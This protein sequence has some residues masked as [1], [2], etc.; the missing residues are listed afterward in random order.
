FISPE[1]KLVTAI[2]ICEPCNS[3]TFRIEGTELACGNCETRWKLNN[4]E[5]LQGS[6][7]KYPPAPIASQVIGNEVQIDERLVKNWKT[8]I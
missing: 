5:G 7:Q 6:C 3:H 4:L 1:G 8:R 2:R